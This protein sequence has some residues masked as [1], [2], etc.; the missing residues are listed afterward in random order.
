MISYCHRVL[1][2][3]TY[4]NTA[5]SGPRAPK[6]RHRD[7]TTRGYVT[8]MQCPA[9]STLYTKS[10]VCFPHTPRPRDGGLGSTPLTA[11]ASAGVVRPSCRVREPPRGDISRVRKRL[12]AGP[13][14]THALAAMADLAMCIVV[15]GSSVSVDYVL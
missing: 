5:S 11:A 3:V 15:T 13:R 14:D 8:R 9:P 7:S 10:D 12:S 6:S 4:Q 1:P 2:A